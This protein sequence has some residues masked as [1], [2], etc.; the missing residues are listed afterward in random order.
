MR[1]GARRTGPAGAAS[2]A[3]ARSIGGNEVV[4]ERAVVE[5]DHFRLLPVPYQAGDE[6]VLSRRGRR[7]WILPRGHPVDGRRPPAIANRRA[8]LIVCETPPR[9]I[10]YPAGRWAAA[11]RQSTDSAKA[12]AIVRL[13]ANR[14]AHRSAA[15]ARFR[16]RQRHQSLFTDIRVGRPSA[17]KRTIRPI[18]GSAPCER[19]CSVP[20]PMNLTPTVE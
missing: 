16:L 4:I 7:P 5:R 20:E 15:R 6:K 11:G 3:D 8:R 14:S 17:L 10:L 12:V 18:L 2:M 1:A 19:S 13:S 9:R